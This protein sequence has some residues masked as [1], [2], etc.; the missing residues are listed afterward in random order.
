MTRALGGDSFLGASPGLVHPGFRNPRSVKLS[1]AF[2]YSPTG[3]TVAGLHWMRNRTTRL[4]GMR[5][6]NLPVATTRPDDPAAIPYYDTGNRPVG[7][8]GSVLVQESLGHADYDGLTASWKYLGD[9]FQL[10]SHYTYARAYSSDI[11]EGFFWGPL[12]TDQARPQDAYGPSNLDM[13]HQLTG[14]AV[15][16]L[17]GGLTW[18]AIVRATSGPP[19]SPQAG[20]DLNGDR[21]DADRALQAPGRYFPRNGFRNRGMTNV[22]MRILR[23]F[24][25]A[26]SSS[27]ELSFE[28]FNALNLDNVEYGGFNTIYG[29]G[30]DLA[31]GAPRAPRDSFLRL[32]SPGGRGYDR[33]NRQVTGVGPLQAQVGLRFRF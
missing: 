26:E 28:L 7:N 6:Y 29:P 11:N 12:Y 30:L 32:R 22:D 8:L 21:Y 25:I 20:T 24:G 17:P 10:V 1:L 23:R 13:R 14:H 31:T 33:N 27:L 15:L 3:N 2:E 5:D 19:L 4:Q 9:R 18:S 16:A